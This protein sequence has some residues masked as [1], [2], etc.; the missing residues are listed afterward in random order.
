MK[1]ALNLQNFR[2]TGE[3]FLKQL[4]VEMESL[5]LPV[6]TLKADHLC[7]RVETPEQY[8]IYKLALQVE[9]TLLIESIVNGRPIATFQLKEPFQVQN[10][11]IELVELPAP[12]PGFPYPLG[13]EH[14]EFVIQES[15]DV[16]AARFPDLKFSKAGN[17][18]MNP[19]L[20]LKLTAGQVK[21]HHLSLARVIEIEEAQFL[22]IIFDL[23]GTLIHSR[24]AIYEI[25]RAVFSEA[26]GRDVPLAE[27]KE[28]F[29]TEFSKL[30]EAFAIECPDKKKRAVSYWGQ[31]SETFSYELF[32]GV[33]NLLKELHGRKYRL[34]LW[35][36]RDES[37]AR[38]ILVH[39]EIESVF[40]TLSFASVVDSKPHAASL[41]FD[42][43]VASSNSVLMIGDSSTDMLGSKN[44]KA[45]A[46]AALWDPHVSE[47]SLI[48]SGAELFFRHPRELSSWL[49]AKI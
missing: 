10:Q 41:K 33:A 37:S 25:N 49:Q 3:S 22:D 38:K 11:K 12:K 1:T 27:I 21:F 13:F 44:V 30:F 34:H 24:D 20:C 39:H 47:H 31:V 9:N 32:D 35:T 29:H 48:S 2:S 45:V 42:W 36:A 7:F 6:S 26:L 5:R 14:A 28:K 46:A 17:P 15:F 19:E 23:D 16:F 4:L 40:T 18:N 8:E 43:G